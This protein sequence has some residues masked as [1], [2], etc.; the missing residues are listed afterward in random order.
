MLFG[1][2]IVSASGY[3]TVKLTIDQLSDGI[4]MLGDIR[5][6]VSLKKR[7]LATIMGSYSTPE[8]EQK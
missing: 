1:E 3:P 5:G 7:D 6:R 2:K 8:R 4:A